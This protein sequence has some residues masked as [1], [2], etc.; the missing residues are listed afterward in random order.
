MSGD[1]PYAS[2]DA[3]RTASPPEYERTS[4]PEG[5]EPEE[6]GE[7]LFAV[8]QEDWSARF[9]TGE[10]IPATW[11]TPIRKEVIVC[12]THLMSVKG[13]CTE[14]FIGE[15]GADFCEV[16]KKDGVKD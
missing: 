8:Q 4:Y 16:C 7:R 13:T 14:S 15:P 5:E 6:P 1:F 2:Y 9:E 10:L 11:S 3:W 12:E